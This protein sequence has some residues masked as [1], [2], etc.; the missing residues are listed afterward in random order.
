MYTIYDACYRFTTVP[1]VVA[2]GRSRLHMFDLG[3]GEK[4]G[5]AALSLSAIGNVLIAIFN[6]QKHLPFK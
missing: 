1:V 5:K 3:G 4:Q 2:G 6:G